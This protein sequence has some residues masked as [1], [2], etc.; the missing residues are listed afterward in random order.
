MKPLKIVVIGAGIVGAASALWLRRAGHDVTLIER[1]TPGMGAS[2]GNGGILARAAIVPVTQPGT[3]TKA[4]RYLLDPNFPLFLRPGYLPRLLPW[5][6]RHLSHANAR[7]TQQIARALTALIGDSVT[8]HKALS[9]GTPAAAW[10]RESS[11]SFAY[12]DRA[13]FDADAY[14]WGVRREA[15]FVPELIEGPAVQEAEPIL[16]P[17]FTLLAVN[18][19]HG[20]ILNPGDYVAALVRAFQD[21]GGHFLEAEVRDFSLAGGQLSAVM[22]DQG[23]IEC[24]RAVIAGGIWS[25]P[26]MRKLGLNVPLEAERG[27]HIQFKSPSIVPNNPMMIAAGKFV[28]TPMD[29]GLRCAGIVEFGGLSAKKSRAPLAF[30]RRK[31]R[32]SFPAL[33]AGETE[34]WL[35]YRPTLPDSLPMIGEVA[36]TG[37]F[38]GFGHQ[39]IGLTG[40]AKTGRIIA[41]LIA[42]NPASI[43]MRPFSPDR[44]T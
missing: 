38:A 25:K 40:G 7:D 22:S 11:Y 34:E 12:R 6:I 21:M 42:G 32:A 3:L 30:L 10:L 16:A 15:G 26:L 31:T 43:D 36:K 33:Q 20:F 17:D 28:V 1:G 29:S 24:T 35:G 41:D 8:Q 9:A 37:V 4:P 27:Y 19:A 14:S 39:H 13:E 18:K 5:L 44:F 23:Q 2:Y